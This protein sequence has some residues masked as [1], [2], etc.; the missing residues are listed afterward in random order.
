MANKF[1]AIILLFC[2]IS[3]SCGSTEKTVEEADSSDEPDRP[4]IEIPDAVV[5]EYILEEFDETERLFVRTRS[6]IANQFTDADQPMPEIYL[7][8]AVEE[9]REVDPYAGYRVQLLSTRDVAHADETRDDFVAWADSVVAGYEPDAY[10]MFRPPNYR[11]RAG[12]FQ[13]RQQAIEFSQ[14]L[15]NRYP[16]AWVVHDRIEPDRVPADTASIEF[17]EFPLPTMD[18]PED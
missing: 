18:I 7:R 14:M 11:V 3:I 6:Q 15:K 4:I 9:E 2:L 10:V 8:D 17:L 13:D 16:D 12:D 1:T 5:D